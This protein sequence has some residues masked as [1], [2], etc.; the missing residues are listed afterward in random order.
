METATRV[1]P[2]WAEELRQKYGRCR[3]YLS[4]HFNVFGRCI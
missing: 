3:Q 4:D 1:L 2:P